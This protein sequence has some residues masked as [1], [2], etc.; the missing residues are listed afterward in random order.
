MVSYASHTNENYQ[1]VSELEKIFGLIPQKH[2]KIL[3]DWLSIST[4]FMYTN[5]RD[6]DGKPECT[7]FELGHVTVSPA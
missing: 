5:W 2:F 1:A 4:L 7:L 3:K 6:L